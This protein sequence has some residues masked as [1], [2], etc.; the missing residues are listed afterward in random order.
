MKKKHKFLIIIAIL[1][2]LTG[3]TKT[4]RDGK[5]TVTYEETGQTLTANILVTGN[6][7]FL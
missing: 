3:C 5:K 4:V 1:L 2:L 6:N 7:F